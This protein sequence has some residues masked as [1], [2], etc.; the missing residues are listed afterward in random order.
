MPT[1]TINGRKIKTDRVLTD[2]EIDEIAMDLGGSSAEIPV[3]ESVKAPAAVP[4]KSEWERALQNA[5][6]GAMAVPPMAA[7]A[8]G[9]QLIT[10]GTKAAPYLANLAKALV[11]QSGRALAAEGAIGAAGGVVGGEL[12]Q[13]VAQKFGEQYRPLGEFGGGALGGLAANTAVRNIPEALMAATRP[14]QTA[15][16]S[17]ASKLL[18][19][20]RARTQLETAMEANPSLAGDLARAAE[21][22]KLTGVRLP[23]LPAAKG[24]TTLEGLVASQTSRAENSGFTAFLT[25]QEKNAWEEVA[26]AQKKL[27]ANPKSI[28]AYV[29]LQ[30]R[31]AEATNAANAA[32]F[33]RE[34]ETREKK[35]EGLNERIQS[36]TSQMVV[37]D[38]GKQAIGSRIKNVLDAKEALIR[39]ELSPQYDEVLKEAKKAGIELNPQQ[40]AGLYNFVKQSRSEDVFASFPTLYRKIQTVFGPQVVSVS[41]KMQE[42]YPNLF[43]TQQGTFKPADVDD[44]DSLKRELNKAFRESK[45]PNQLR[46]L[47]DFKKQFD[48][49]VDTLPEDFVTKYRGLDEEYAVRLGIPFNKKGV[50]SI[51]KA[52]FVEDSVPKLTTSPSTIQ[53]V[54]AATDNNQEAVKAIQDAFLFKLSNTSR[55]VNPVTGE[56]NPAQLNAFIKANKEAID[57]VPGLRDN[58]LNVS[59]NVQTLKNARAS[60]LEAQKKAQVEKFSNV[61]SEAFNT[62]GGFEGYVNSALSTPE[63]MLE[64][65]RLAGG[66]K[67]LQNG[68]KSSI[69]D[70][71][72]ARQNKMQ[73]FEDNAKTFDALFGPEYSKNVKA[74]LEAAERLDKNP[75]KTKI[76]LGISQQTRFQQMTGTKP[77]QAATEWRNPILGPYRVAANVLSRFVQNRTTKAENEEI[78]EFLKNPSAMKDAAELLVELEKGTT[79]GIERAKELLVKLGKNTASAG[80]FGGLAAA[81]PGEMGVTAREPVRTY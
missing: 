4:Q 39:K 58:L 22:E 32:K 31:K 29:E 24:D 64:L 47:S 71:G 16:V 21:I 17:E 9:L 73:F 50:V 66:N 33:A 55:I 7:A 75:L 19:G 46:I 38:E 13:Q 77:E 41:G 72:L 1:Y 42:K 40:V 54:L 65:M 10:Q 59:R 49:V 2:D 18:G 11:P 20:V 44:I 28:D 5:T 60:V 52:R 45:D 48:A 79:K 6:A 74:L 43:R 36:L 69:L 27:A 70:I 23:V 37:S 76:N 35:I 15:A 26:K 61:W 3:D 68:L 62:R 53:Q 14:G 81:V 57:A 63:R 30:A 25:G 8:R 51:E 67:V 78:Q 12:G 34:Q 56:L 80:I